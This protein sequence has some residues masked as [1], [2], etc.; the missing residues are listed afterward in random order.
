MGGGRS[1]HRKQHDDNDDDDDVDILYLYIFHFC[2]SLSQA[3][4]KW[5][6]RSDHEN[7]VCGFVSKDFRVKKLYLKYGAI[8]LYLCISLSVLCFFSVFV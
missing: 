4:I 1:I 5:H 8:I 3:S 6:I 7:I 2:F